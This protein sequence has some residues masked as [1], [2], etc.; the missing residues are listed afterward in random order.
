MKA[1]T[2]EEEEEAKAMGQSQSSA[3]TF[4]QTA[5]PH[6]AQ[7]Q[8]AQG[9]AQAYP[10]GDAVSPHA[11]MQRRNSSQSV[12]VPSLLSTD[13][14]GERGRVV[15][16]KGGVQIPIQINGQAVKQLVS[17]TNNTRPPV[18]P[19]VPVPP[20]ATSANA[21][22]EAE[23][24][25]RQTRQPFIKRSFAPLAIDTNADTA[26]ESGQA[27]AGANGALNSA[28]HAGAAAMALPSPSMG[29]P[30]LQSNPA[31]LPM[32]GS[33]ANMSL[34]ESQVYLP[35]VCVFP[36]LFFSRLLANSLLLPVWVLGSPMMLGLRTHCF[37]RGKFCF[38]M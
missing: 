9:Q 17:P 32:Y 1:Q 29:P 34:S 30:S 21:S 3:A 8:Q 36:P 23:T 4:P 6:L 22:P 15:S 14:L 11:G 18:V 20:A 2:E 13:T 37:F 28:T 12:G 27:A 7:G 10:Q 16:P 33:N 35:S 31:G 38:R 26:G 24:S 25:A 5:S 19:S